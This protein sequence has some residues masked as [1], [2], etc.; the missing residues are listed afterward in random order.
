MNHRRLLLLLCGLAVAMLVVSGVLQRSAPRPRHARG[1]QQALFAQTG[2]EPIRQP[3][4]RRLQTGETERPPVEKAGKAARARAESREVDDGSRKT[5][6]QTFMRKKLAS[7]STVLEGLVVEDYEMLVRGART[8]QQVSEAEQWRISNDAM[9]RQFSNEFVRRIRR[10]EESAREQRIDGA[11][12]AYVEATLS[13]I[14]C[15][16][17]VRSVIVAQRRPN[18]VLPLANG[19]D[20]SAETRS[21]VTRVK[22]DEAPHGRISVQLTGLTQT[23][24]A[25]ADAPEER[26]QESVERFMRKKLEASQGV[27]EGLVGERFDLI[28]QGADAMKTMNRAAAWQVFKSPEYV[29]YSEEF[30][31]VSSQLSED[32]TNKNLEAAALTSMRLTMNCVRCHSHVR[33]LEVADRPQPVRPTSK[34][35]AAWG[36][37]SAARRLP[38]ADVA[39]TRT[40]R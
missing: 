32:A 9:Y 20:S 25:Q 39:T 13:C 29:L 12:L 38:R 16:K 4:A 26:A 31:R 10:L 8:L 35:A 1:F 37:G 17:W 34:S 30:R 15:H 33:K 2:S 40:F 3:A 36:S 24:A 21:P 11:T 14:E 18:S 23:A 7:T 19:L 28:K 6:L 5:P 27:L 22:A